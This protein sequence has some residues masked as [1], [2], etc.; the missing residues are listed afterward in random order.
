MPSSP[1]NESLRRKRLLLRR[2]ARTENESAFFVQNAM[3]EEILSRLGDMRRAF[4]RILATDFGPTIGKSA[5]KRAAKADDVFFVNEIS[6][7]A[8]AV[9]ALGALPFKSE[10]FDAFIGPI[11][12]HAITDVPGCLREWRR[13]LKKDGMLLAAFVGETTLQSFRRAAIRAEEEL[14]GRAVPRFY[15][16]IDVKTAGMLLRSAGF[17]ACVA[18]VDVVGAVYSRAKTLIE[19]V[20]IIGENGACGEGVP[21]PPRG[22]LNAVDAAFGN[23]EIDARFDVIYL[24][25]IKE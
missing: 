19:D 25:G 11:P 18:D 16:F 9:C 13:V 4:P 10:T 5:V 6:L 24:T 12:L 15:P 23:G 21:L 14:S 2:A 22:W 20:R 3:A 17:D 1:F 8:D 7:R